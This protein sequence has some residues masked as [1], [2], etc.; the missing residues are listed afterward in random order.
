MIGVLNLFNII[1]AKQD[2]YD[3]YFKQ[4]RPLLT[5]HQAR[6][7]FYGRTRIVCLGDY[8]QEYC[9]LVLYP[10]IHAVKSLSIDPDFKRIRKLRD[11]S[12]SDFEMVILD[13]MILDC[14]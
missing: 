2:L 12:T 14:P 8:N 1:P 9:G 4:V 3:A 13:E 6:L 7:L 11:G 10:D 5:R